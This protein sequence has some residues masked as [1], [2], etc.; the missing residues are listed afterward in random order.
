MLTVLL[1]HYRRIATFSGGMALFCA[2][3]LIDLNISL[4]AISYILAF[5]IFALIFS[6]I[7]VVVYMKIPR[8]RGLLEIF[9][10]AA[11]IA[12]MASLVWHGNSAISAILSLTTF[13]VSLAAL[14]VLLRSKFSRG[15]STSTAWRDR[16]SGQVAYPARLIW[17]HVVPGAAEPIDHCTGTVDR[18]DVDKED[19]DSIHIKFKTRKKRGSE[20]TLT[21]LERNEPSTC[22]FFF[23][24]RES[25]GTMVDGI[26]SLHISVMDRDSCFVSC[27]EER[28]GLSFGARVERWFDDALGF[29][30]DKLLEKLDTLYGD[31]Y[32][33]RKSSMMTA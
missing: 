9:G 27:I 8:K 25:D 19:P 16:Y 3:I 31:K 20:Y 11:F 32:G 33:Q 30:H 15:I 29:Q 24:G 6:A 23:Q 28:S 14:W 1:R 12:C 4:P 26:F 22:R 21:F 13:V 10:T 5:L 2:L 7:S 18:Y 17:R